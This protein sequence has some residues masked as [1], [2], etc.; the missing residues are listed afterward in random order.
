MEGDASDGGGGG[1]VNIMIATII[2]GLLILIA[3]ITG[4]FQREEH[5]FVQVARRLLQLQHNESWEDGVG[6]FDLRYNHEPIISIMS[7]ASPAKHPR[8][9]LNRRPP[10]S[11]V[12]GRR[13]GAIQPQF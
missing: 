7:Y 4:I 13:K 10:T 8:M 12:E 9:Q 3:N 1:L 6:G 11:L 5:S 2:I